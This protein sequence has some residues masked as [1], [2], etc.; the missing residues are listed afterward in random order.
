[1]TTRNTATKIKSDH[2]GNRIRAYLASMQTNPETEFNSEVTTVINRGRSL[3][4]RM[5][6]SCPADP[7]DDRPTLKLTPADC[8]HILTYMSCCVPIDG[9]DWWD[10]HPKSGS[11]ISHVCGYMAVLDAMAESLRPSEEEPA[12]ASEAGTEGVPAGLQMKMSQMENTDIL[13]DRIRNIRALA[14]VLAHL[15]DAPELFEDTLNDVAC[16]IRDQANEAI[17]AQDALEDSALAI[18]RAAKVAEVQS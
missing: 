2:T 5:A 16:V 14:D 7:D 1:M 3:M 6:I 13:N 8:V 11:D 15:R 12:E 10:D 9:Q 4:E 18:D 17:A